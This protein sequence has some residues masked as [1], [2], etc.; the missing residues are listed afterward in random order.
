MNPQL[1]ISLAST[2]FS[3]AHYL[4]EQV[5]Q[6]L[7]IPRSQIE[8]FELTT[9]RE[10][11]LLQFAESFGAMQQDEGIEDAGFRNPNGA[12]AFLATAFRICGDENLRG[13]VLARSFGSKSKIP[14]AVQELNL[15]DTY[16]GRAAFV[17]ACAFYELV[18]VG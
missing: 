11:A 9:A 2:E 14:L 6:L 13:I 1:G 16:P 10:S 4:F 5:V 8:G 18:P 3:Q 7:E 15:P 12:R 17:V